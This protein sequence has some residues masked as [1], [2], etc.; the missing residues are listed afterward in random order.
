MPYTLKNFNSPFILNFYNQNDNSNFN[1]LN[2]EKIIDLEIVSENV[3]ADVI[4]SII[5]CLFLEKGMEYTESFIMNEF[6]LINSYKQINFENEN[7][8]KMNKNEEVELLKFEK[9]LNLK[10]VFKN[11]KLLI[12]SLTHISYY[13]NNLSNNFEFFKNF[14]KSYQR[15]EFLGDAC[16]INLFLK[17]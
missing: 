11:K 3:I 12:E 5:G 10:Y 9:K 16:I 8:Y 14:K 4:E 13:N 7:D 1:K 6:N 15:L 2:K 17:Y